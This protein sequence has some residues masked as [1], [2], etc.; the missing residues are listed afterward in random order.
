M[1]LLIAIPTLD[2]VNYQFVDCLLKLTR[3]LD[4]DGVDF[5]VRLLGGTLVYVARDKLARIAIN[6][7]FTHVLWLDADM[8]FTEELVEDLTFAGKPFV[9]G[10]CHG[11]RPPH[12]SCLFKDLDLVMR[13]TS[14]PSG[15]FPI[16]GCG[17]GCVL[18]ETEILAKVMEAYKTCF[19]PSAS[20]GEDLMFCKRA[21]DLGFKLYADGGVRLGH[22]GQTTIYAEDHDVWKAN[23]INYHED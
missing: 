8:I 14:Y 10:I 12:L 17:F 11:R 13:F 21:A 3:R 22:I 16:A 5:D 19:L 7:G 9:S 18:M 15:V 1:K 23:V 4:R 6:G 2:Y 20:L